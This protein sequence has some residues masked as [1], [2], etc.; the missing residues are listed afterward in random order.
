MVNEGRRQNAK[1]TG[2]NREVTVKNQQMEAFLLRNL[3]RMEKI[4]TKV[5]QI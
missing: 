4:D 2:E 5:K 3:M 1:W